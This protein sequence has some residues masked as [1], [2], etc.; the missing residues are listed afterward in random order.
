ML[1]MVQVFQ[2]S[3]FSRSMFFKDQAF[4]GLSSGSATMVRVRISQDGQECFIEHRLKGIFT[5]PF[6]RKHFHVSLDY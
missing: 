3:G 4:Q 6:S 1:F 5:E 2:G